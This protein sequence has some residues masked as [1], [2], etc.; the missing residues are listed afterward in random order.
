MMRA[1]DGK[2]QSHLEWPNSTGPQDACMTNCLHPGR[3]VAETTNCLLSTNALIS[4]YIYTYVNQ[5]TIW[6][7]VFTQDGVWPKPVI[8]MISNSVSP[9]MHACVLLEYNPL[10]YAC[11]LPTQ[12]VKCL[13]RHII[14]ATAIS[15]SHHPDG[16]SCSLN[17]PCVHL[18]PQ[19][20]RLSSTK[21]GCG[22]NHCYPSTPVYCLTFVSFC[23]PY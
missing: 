17:R 20:G 16:F 12:S 8:L 5:T 13:N 6:L 10:F 3:D 2:L 9:P 1:E 15:I 4:P 7:T 19:Y 18:R 14:V 22:Q 21:K 11:C 23:K